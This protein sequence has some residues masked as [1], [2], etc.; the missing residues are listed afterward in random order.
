MQR[1][2]F[3]LALAVFAALAACATPAGRLKQDVSFVRGCWV[4]KATPDGPVTGFLR[5]LP[6]PEKSTLGGYL[7]FITDG[8][9]AGASIYFE[10]DTDGSH[11]SITAPTDRRPPTL[12]YWAM[13]APQRAGQPAAQRT[14]FGFFPQ[15]AE[16]IAV[17]GDGERLDIYQVE[18]DGARGVT[19]FKGE[20]DGCD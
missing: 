20:R 17:D 2:R 3:L 16:I 15:P 6:H 12:H 1:L 13:I 7:Q 19:L 10:V 14:W 11:L 4:A 8:R 9:E 5:L 18:P